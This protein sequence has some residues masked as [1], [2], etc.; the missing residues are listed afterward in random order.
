RSPI[1]ALRDD[2]RDA[3]AHARIAGAVGQQQA[4]LG[5]D[6]RTLLVLQTPGTQYALEKRA[7]P[8]QRRR[9]LLRQFALDLSL[10]NRF[11]VLLD[12][13]V[14]DPCG[15]DQR[16]LRRL[17]PSTGRLEFNFNFVW[18]SDRRIRS[19]KWAVGPSRRV[20]QKR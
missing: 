6:A 15:S 19:I 13:V 7:G 12:P 11:P 18:I 17:A 10:Q 5:G 3:R 2:A 9:S 1:P 16:R 8:P 14:E 4:E 20:K